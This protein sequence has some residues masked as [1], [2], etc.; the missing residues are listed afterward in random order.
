DTSVPVVTVQLGEPV[1]L[2]CALT[3]KFQAVTWVHWYK[4]SA[5][6]TLTLIA[7]QR[8]DMPSTYGPGFSFSRFNITYDGNKSSL[9]ISSIFKQD[10]GMYHCGHMDWTESTF[11][12]TTL[13]Y[14]VVQESTLSDPAL[15]KDSETLQCSVLFDYE[16]PTCSEE[17]S[18][19]WF[20]AGSDKS[21]P[22]LIYMDRKISKN[23][24]EGSFSTKR[25]IYNFSKNI[26][27]SDAGTYYCAVATCG[28][29]LFG[30]GTNLKIRAKPRLIKILTF[31]MFIIFVLL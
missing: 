9:F 7:M 30:N 13:A 11:T 27:S 5:G 14:T 6:N 22:D 26:I 25:C 29:I 24:E 3:E 1:T 12:G 21:L 15:P 2:T 4:Q 28:E 16:N 20:R 31:L 10:E 19:F 23:C 17:P 18:V 8:N